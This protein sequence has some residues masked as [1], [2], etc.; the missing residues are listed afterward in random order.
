MLVKQCMNF[1]GDVMKVKNLV[2]LLGVASVSSIAAMGIPEP[3]K[4]LSDPSS[5]TEME[6]R[7]IEAQKRMHG[8]LQQEGA[9]FSKQNRTLT[10]SQ[11][12]D[13]PFQKCSDGSG[14]QRGRC[15]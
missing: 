11:F 4:A 10:I 8:T 6:R 9:K 13:V 14:W 3:A 5:M 1:G 2:K 15:D 7:I 12:A